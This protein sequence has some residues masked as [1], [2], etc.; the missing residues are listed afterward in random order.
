M[1]SALAR[2]LRGFLFFVVAAWLIL[3]GGCQTIVK[4]A[5]N[6]PSVAGTIMAGANR[7][8]AQPALNALP[9]TGSGI[10]FTSNGAPL[11]QATPTAAATAPTQGVAGGNV[12]VPKK[13]KIVV[14]GLPDSAKIPTATPY[15][16]WPQ[17]S[18]IAS[19][20][21]VFANLGE[22]GDGW[23]CVQIPASGV[24][25]CSADPFMV[26]NPTAQEDLARML[27]HGLVKGE[28]IGTPKH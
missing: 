10:V 18:P 1:V 6:A 3:A 14:R 4:L 8:A 25:A 5:G 16:T 2:E 11:P 28:A 13:D 22:P 27:L 21:Y 26:D 20:E 23:W 19:S 7:L 12:A 17:P 9:V 15:P 24:Q